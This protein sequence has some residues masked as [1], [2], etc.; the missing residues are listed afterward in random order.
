MKSHLTSILAILFLAS[1]TTH[2]ASNVDVT[3]IKASKVVVEDDVITIVA[4]AMTRVTLI[5]GDH[6]PAY[7]GAQ[8]T[9][10]PAT[11]TQVKSDK[12]TLIIKRPRHPELE[13]A[14]EMSVRAA[15]GLQEGKEVGRIGFYTP[16]ISI[17]G[18]LIHSITGFG[19]LYPK[20][21]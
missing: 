12:A 14:W 6:D 18:N 17:K 13:D 3:I 10:R 15:K 7:K 21:Q 1:T 2:A 8:F 4:E 5:Q 9:G 16:D 19:F 11:H 20:G